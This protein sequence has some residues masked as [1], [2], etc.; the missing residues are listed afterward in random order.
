MSES[1]TKPVVFARAGSKADIWVVS[2]LEKD[3][4]WI[5][6]R[7]G[8]SRF[9]VMRPKMVLVPWGMGSRSFIRSL[10]TSEKT[11]RWFAADMLGVGWCRYGLGLVDWS[12]FNEGCWS[13]ELL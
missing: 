9:W 13:E 3:K 11:S 1:E 6:G 12:W 8:E 5:T 7:T 10:T 2:S 4:C